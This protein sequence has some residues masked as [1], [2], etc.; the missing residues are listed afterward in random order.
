MIF[1]VIYYY[2]CTVVL[3]FLPPILV[4]YI[5]FCYFRSYD[6]PTALRKVGGFIAA[7]S[8]VIGVPMG[9]TQLYNPEAVTYQ[10]KLEA[11]IFGEEKAN[12]NL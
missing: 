4:G 8:L 9:L 7:V 10:K 11:Q 6:V 1:I 5:L 12:G 3:K 2:A